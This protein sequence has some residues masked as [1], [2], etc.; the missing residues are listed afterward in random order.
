MNN[1]L[2]PE[3]SK[4]RRHNGRLTLIVNLIVSGV[5]DDGSTWCE[6]TRTENVSTDGAFFLLNQEVRVGDAV[7]LRLQ[8]PE[9]DERVEAQGRVIR[10]D[11]STYGAKRVGV[12]I[13]PPEDG[14][15]GFVTSLTV[16]EE[17]TAGSS[18]RRVQW[19]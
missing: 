5:G 1:P 18:R 8:H 15:H 6:P 4:D 13:E 11:L 14:W 7:V 19:P 12:R 2:S 10:T 17:G 16:Q 9:R 3:P